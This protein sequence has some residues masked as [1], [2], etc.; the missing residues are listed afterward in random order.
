MHKDL[1][2]LNYKLYLINSDGFPTNETGLKNHCKN[3]FQVETISG[4]GHY[5]MIEKPAEFNVNIRKSADRNE[6]TAAYADGLIKKLI[7][8]SV[9]P[10]D[11]VR[12]GKP[13]LLRREACGNQRG[14]CCTSCTLRRYA[15]PERLRHF[16]IK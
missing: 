1:E 3:G 16:K 4:T 11:V 7:P 5:P 14:V 8:V 2:Q 6:I 13:F 12:K 10:S 9:R 15:P